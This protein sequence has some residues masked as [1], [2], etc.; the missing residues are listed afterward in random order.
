[1]DCRVSR[2]SVQSPD[3]GRVCICKTWV[4]QQYQVHTNGRDRRGRVHPLL[5]RYRQT[6]F[7]W[8]MVC[9][10]GTAWL[11]RCQNM[12]S[13]KSA[14]ILAD[15][16]QIVGQWIQVWA[17]S[18]SM[19]SEVV[20]SCSWMPR[21]R[22]RARL[23]SAARVEMVRERVWWNSRHSAEVFQGGMRT[24]FVMRGT[25]KLDLATKDTPK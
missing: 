21:A 24:C 16:Q 6:W 17:P 19:T 2:K 9:W 3:W 22:E 8:G 15:R 4:G 20:R 18:R 14:H 10:S 5:P 23:R 1:M 12:A 7:I 13:L 25:V 11:L